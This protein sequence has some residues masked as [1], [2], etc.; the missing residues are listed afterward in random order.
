MPCI[1]IQID[2]SL[3][4]VLEVVVM[5]SQPRQAALK[6]AGHPMPP[7]QKATFLVDTGASC[8]CVDNRIIQ[9]L[10]IPATGSTN[11]QTP[12]T[13]GGVHSC[14]VYDTMLYVP[15]NQGS[16]G[17]IIPALPMVETQL[18]SQGIDGLLGRDVLNNCMLVFNGTAGFFSI[19]H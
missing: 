7:N 17:Y 19:A 8:S 1:N 6:A 3:G 16:P 4:P 10:G 12:S 15:G 13:A 5:P 9:A 14:D 18:S 2:P 11:I